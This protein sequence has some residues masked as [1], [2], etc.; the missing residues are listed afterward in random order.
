M[1]DPRNY[2]TYKCT[3]AAASESGG[4][5]A[6]GNAVGK[7]GDL[8]ILNSVG[9]GK[10][11]QG[12]RTMASISNTIRSGCGSLPT[13]IGS[14]IESGANWV[15][16]QTGI[17]STVVDAVRGF[18]P[19]IA[20]Q[21]WGQAKSIFQQVKQG[22]FTMSSI[23]GALQDL[24][25]LERLGRNIFTGTGGSSMQS[26]EC[27]NSPYA[28]DLI[29]RA[30]KHKF[31]FVVS[32]VF[33][34]GY[35]E[36]TTVANEM[37]FVVKKSTRPNIRFQ[38]E[39][40]NYYNF[41]SKYVTKTEFEDMSMTFHDDMQN[42]ALT[43]YNAYR[44][45]ISPITNMG[46]GLN[47]ILSPET[48]G[49]EFGQLGAEKVSSVN[50]SNITSPYAAS[51]GPLLNNN[52]TIIRA[53]RMFHV[54]DGGRYMNVFTFHNPRITEMVL[55]D[56]DMADSA[57]NEVSLKFAY[58]SVYIETGLNANDTSFTT[59]TT[60]L[61]SSSTGAM[62]PL[63]YNETPGAMSAAIKAQQP[64]GAQGATAACDAMGGINTGSA[65]GLISSAQDALKNGMSTVSK[66]LDGF[67][68]SFSS[69]LD[70]IGSSIGN[71]SDQAQSIASDIFDI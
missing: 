71:M 37:A 27:L 13:S 64:Y 8:Q 20:N 18:N 58:D 19:A 23:P 15:L 56:V 66:A 54:Y 50:M 2:M 59:G 55:D 65:G 60:F 12:L 28:L 16:D 44:N 10:I 47:G 31:L 69:G 30:P 36:L 42:M 25:N 46:S 67:S 24:Q 53:I 40:V 7:I 33:N 57:G 43:F 52:N 70:Q 1:A 32:F 41:R 14:T 29:A 63:R 51:S 4:L 62:Y 35:E 34:P 39:D 21:A 49:M 61:P 68:S 38:T 26:V 6:F 11:G 22:K 3:V 17:G 9:A 45:S 5:R 48:R